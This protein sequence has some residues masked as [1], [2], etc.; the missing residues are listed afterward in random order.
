MYILLH[1]KKITS[2]IVLLVFKIVK[3]FSVSLR[4][5]TN[6]NFDV[7]LAK[8]ATVHLVYLRIS[9]FLYSLICDN[10]MYGT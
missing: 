9:F 6:S 7:K 4:E 5:K 10:G 1:I 8:R 2:Y 3:T